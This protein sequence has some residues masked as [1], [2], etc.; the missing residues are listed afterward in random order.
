MNTIYKP[1]K[2]TPY[3]IDLRLKSVALVENGATILHVAKL[4]NL[5]YATIR[6]WLKLKRTTNS[7]APKSNYHKGHSNK[8][9]D[10]DKFKEFVEQNRGSTSVELAKLWGNVTAVTIRNHLH[11]IGYTRK[12]RVFYTENETKKNVRYIWM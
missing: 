4:L 7:V 1:R 8:I 10:L 5:G 3:S 12:K 9:P 11:K 6:R 2:T